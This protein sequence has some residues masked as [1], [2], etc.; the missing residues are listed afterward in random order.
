MV[1]YRSFR[2]IFQKISLV[3]AFIDTNEKKWLE[4]EP[5]A[6]IFNL[7]FMVKKNPHI[8]VLLFI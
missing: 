1:L 8:S 3:S 2:G 6:H 7:L 5:K 4:K